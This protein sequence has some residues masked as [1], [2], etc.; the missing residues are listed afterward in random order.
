MYGSIFRHFQESVPKIGGFGCALAR[1][2]HNLYGH[3]Y[4]MGCGGPADRRLSPRTD[5]WYSEARRMSAAIATQEQNTECVAAAI[6]IT[7]SY[8]STMRAAVHTLITTGSILSKP[9]LTQLVQSYF[10]DEVRV[11]LSQSVYHA[12]SPHFR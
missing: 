2:A 7:M 6:A 5:H 3:Y 4:M 10:P 12:A 11:R 1:N 8:S 9:Y